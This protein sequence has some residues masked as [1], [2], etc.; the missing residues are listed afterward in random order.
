[1]LLA[2]INQKKLLG[3]G[4]TIR[5]LAD[6]GVLGPTQ[7]FSLDFPPTPCLGS[8]HMDFNGVNQLGRVLLLRS[9]CAQ[10][11]ADLI[12]HIPDGKDL[13]I[14]FTFLQLLNH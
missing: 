1:M 8:V 10:P 3:L 7:N 2:L 5:T 4:D 11:V 9:V 6:G 14:A 12:Q 13:G